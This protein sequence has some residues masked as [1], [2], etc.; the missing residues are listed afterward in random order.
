MAK[1]VYA[2]K[3]GICPGIYH[4][5]AQCKA[6]VD[7]FPGA[8]YKGFLTLAE[9]ESY[10]KGAAPG[11]LISEKNALAA[12]QSDSEQSAYKEGTAVAYVDGSYDPA[13][14]AFS[15]G[16]V[17]F[18]QGEK[19]E[20]SQKYTDPKLAE[21]RNVAGEIMGAVSVISYSLEQKIPAL[22]IFYDY[23]GVSKWA[24]GEWK[25]NKEGTKA[26]AQFCR[27]ASEQVQLTFVKVKGHSGDKYN[28]EADRLAKKA[29][30]LA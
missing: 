29:L 10:L 17:F 14:H 5:W 13:T 21:M 12:A 30:G 2:V 22:E 20:F 28:D 4:T 19:K 25:T 11:S 9:A 8:Q 24:L 3:K 7:G 27:K 16:A 23:E 15:C 26:Y 6:Q 1:K 18:Y